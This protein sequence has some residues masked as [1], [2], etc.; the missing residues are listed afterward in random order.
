M[1]TNFQTLYERAHELAM[2]VWKRYGEGNEICRKRCPFGLEDLDR[3]ILAEESRTLDAPEYCSALEKY[4]QGLEAVRDDQIRLTVQE[5]D[6]VSKE[7]EV[8]RY[9]I[10]KYTLRLKLTDG[11]NGF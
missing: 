10:V 9:K 1:T 4:I 5:V 3:S 6:Q 2:E 11:H 8:E 7:R